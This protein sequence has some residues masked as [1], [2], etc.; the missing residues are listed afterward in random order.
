MTD[1]TI[2][3]NNRRNLVI[4]YVIF[5][6]YMISGFSIIYYSKRYDICNN[7]NCLLNMNISDSLINYGMLI[8]LFSFNLIFKITFIYLKIYSTEMIF[9]FIHSLIKFSSGIWLFQTGII[10]FGSN[11]DCIF[12]SYTGIF[13]LMFWCFYFSRYLEY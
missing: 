10:I 12:E 11:L 5:I 6:A 7:T 1:Y 4:C 13:I 2:R 9:E 3:I 8:I